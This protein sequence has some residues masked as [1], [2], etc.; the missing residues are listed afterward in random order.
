MRRYRDGSGDATFGKGLV[1]P[2]PNWSVT[3]MAGFT[4]SVPPLADGA[5]GWMVMPSFV[6]TPAA[7]GCVTLALE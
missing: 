3:A 4:V 5:C 7:R 6:A 2:L 1:V